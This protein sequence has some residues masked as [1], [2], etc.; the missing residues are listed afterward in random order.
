MKKTIFTT[1]GTLYFPAFIWSST[2]ALL[3]PIDSYQIFI[4]EYHWKKK[5][6]FYRSS[7][8]IR[9]LQAFQN[10]A[11]NFNARH[12]APASIYA[13]PFCNLLRGGNWIFS[14]LARQRVDKH[15]DVNLRCREYIDSIEERL[16]SR[17]RATYFWRVLLL[18]CS[19]LWRVVSPFLVFLEWKVT[20]VSDSSTSA[21]E[22]LPSSNFSPRYST[23]ALFLQFFRALTNSAAVFQ[24]SSILLFYTRNNYN[25]IITFG[26]KKMIYCTLKQRNNLI[27]SKQQRY[28]L[29]ILTTTLVTIKGRLFLSVLPTASGNFPQH[30]GGS[31]TPQPLHSAA[32]PFNF[33]FKMYL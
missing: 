5:L 8:Q 15:S 22:S 31:R 14:S 2:I 25:V 17:L 28:I 11:T 12:V 9:F 21:L 24:R 33:R 16:F 6:L 3:F 32:F 20:M 30:H 23:F 18:E 26:W 7:A 27:L 29:G 4:I 10:R 1:K 19:Q 13:I